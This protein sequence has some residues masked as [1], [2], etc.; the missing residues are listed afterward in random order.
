MASPEA[1]ELLWVPKGG[2][3]PLDTPKSQRAESNAAI[4]EAVGRFVRKG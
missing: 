2:H 1:V 3:N 4:L